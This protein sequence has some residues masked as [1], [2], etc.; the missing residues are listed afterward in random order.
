MDALLPP[1]AQP[2]RKLRMRVPG[3]SEPSEE[4]GGGQ[5]KHARVEDQLEG[6]REGVRV[7]LVLEEIECLV[8]HDILHLEGDLGAGMRG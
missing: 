7:W 2:V 3:A 8:S 6:G 5:A 4:P 1:V